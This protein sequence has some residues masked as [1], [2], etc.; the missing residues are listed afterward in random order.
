MGSSSFFSSILCLQFLFF[1]FPFC[2]SSLN[3]FCS[4]DEASALLQF[5]SSFALNSSAS[6]RCVDYQS[7]YPK[8]LSWENGT[9]YCMW[10]GVTCDTLSGHVMALTLVAV[11]FMVNF[12]PISPSSNL[13][14]FKHS[15]FL[16][17]FSIGLKYLLNLVDLWVSHTSTYPSLHLMVTLLMKS[18]T[19]PNW[20][21]L[22][23]HGTGWS[24]NHPF[25]EVSF[26]M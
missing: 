5:K 2:Y 7:S 17:I 4:L 26:T 21:P 20:S 9:D 25:E 16:T 6:A 13:L 19:C 3:P 10:D 18:H 8:T 14:V 24:L 12:I 22:V 11:G 23:S 15:I 1:L